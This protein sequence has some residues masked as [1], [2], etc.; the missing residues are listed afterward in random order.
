MLAIIAV[1]IDSYDIDFCNEVYIARFR[2]M[3]CK[4]KLEKLN[5]T[6]C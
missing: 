1:I 4:E 3:K 2:N 6:G 5:K